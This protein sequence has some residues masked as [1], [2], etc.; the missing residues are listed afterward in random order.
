MKK[1]LLLFVFILIFTSLQSAQAEDGD[2]WDYFGDQNVYG[3]KPVSDKEFEETVQR[4]E[5]K[6]NKTKKMK[7]E[8][9]HQGNET[10][11]LTK[12][13]TE[14]PILS[15]PVVLKLTDNVQLPIGHYQVQG[16]K[17][18]GKVSLKLYQAHYLIA[19]LP[20]KETNDD[21]GHDTVNFVNL[22]TLNDNQVII[23]YGSV[24]FNAY[25]I[26]DLAQ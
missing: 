7:G 14:L 3:Q 16:A 22:D 26:M 9:F 23:E 21:F 13:P 12:V 18:D 24:D 20:A 6:K 10:E 25:A 5:E 8:S 19:E 17:K 1:I 11:F 4:L 15:I 2:M